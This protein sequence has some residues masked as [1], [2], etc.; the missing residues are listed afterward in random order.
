MGAESIPDF[1]ASLSLFRDMSALEVK[2]IS[3]FLEPRRYSKGSVVFRE[4]E[5]GKELFLV[6][7]GR[8]GSYV[9]QPDGTR[10]DVYEFTPGVLFGEMAIIEEEPRSATCFA[11][12]DT[13]LL[14]LDG[15]DFYRL[16]W[17]QPVIGVKLL[18]SMARVMTA[19]LDEASGFLGGL[20][21][22]G[23][24]ARRRAVTDELS[25]LF[26]RRF[27]EETM[28][29]RFARGAGS[30][31]RCAL[32]MLDIDRFRDINAAY[33]AQGGDVAIAAAANAFAPVIREG[34]VGSRLSGDEFAVFL[35]NGGIDRALEL[36][37]AMREAA[38][39]LRLE[40]RTSPDAP[41][42]YAAIT[43]SI[44]AAA[45]PEHA[46]TPEELV[47]AADKALYKAKEGGRNR[48]ERF[49]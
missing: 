13:E 45:S 7:Y 8:V 4:G 29:T 35:P 10:R 40:Y 49:F 1:I 27:L 12:E 41:P 23:E 48:V 30:S 22:W 21:R 47:A 2:A 37:E 33:G 34:E 25:G 20:V 15:I 19:W 6:R 11:M 36:G 46:S 9:T 18:S 39:S 42:S 3:P 28:S 43:V 17:E 14:V 16:V 24:A 38:E 26:N 44:G 32:L 5:S 31:R